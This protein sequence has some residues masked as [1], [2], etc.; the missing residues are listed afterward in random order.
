MLLCPRLLA[1]AWLAALCG[2][3]TLGIQ[4]TA[5][6]TPPGRRE[7]GGGVTVVPV[8]PDQA[9]ESDP[10]VVPFPYARCQFGV[11]E[12]LELGLVWT[13]GPGLGA[14]AKWRL[15]RGP[16]ELAVSARATG[17]VL[18]RYPFRSMVS[19]GVHPRVVLS[20]ETAGASPYC[21]S[22]GVDMWG[23]AGSGSWTGLSVGLGI[24]FRAGSRRQLRVMPELYAVRVVA[25]RGDLG[26]PTVA[27]GVSFCEVAPDPAP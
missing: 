16:V 1:A 21:L 9:E 27:F 19:W 23:E 7:F 13:F 5:R 22:A 18:P 11:A 14:S 25:S 2:C 8:P 24:P 17:F 20:S 12:D 4:E 3:Y 15:Q 10:P 26:S 6:T